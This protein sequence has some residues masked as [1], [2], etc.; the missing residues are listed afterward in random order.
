M[1]FRTALIFTLILIPCSFAQEHGLIN[2]ADSPPGNKRSRD[3]LFTRR[4]M[5][6]ERKRPAAWNDLVYGGQF[7]DRIEAMPVQG[8]RTFET[9]GGDNVKPRYTDNGIE[10]DEWSYWGGNSIPGQDGRHHLIVCRWSEHLPKGHWHYHES[11]V[12]HAVSENPYGPY[13]VE[14]TLFRGHN[15]YIFQLQDGR[16]AIEGRGKFWVSTMKEDST[17]QFKSMTGLAEYWK[18]VPI[19]LNNRARA[20]REQSPMGYARREDGS[21]LMVTRHGDIWISETGV[22]PYYRIT[23]D[24]VYPAIEGRFEDPAIW[25][26]DVQYHL[27]M[28]DWQ[29]R[30]AYH[31]R[32]K[33]GIHWKLDPGVAY[34]PERIGKVE[35]GT[36][37]DWHKY[38]VVR[39]F[40]D[41]HGRATRANFA[42]IDS[43]KAEDLGSDNHN[44]KNLFIPLTPGKQLSMQNE[45]SINVATKKI[46]VKI[47]AEEG[48]NPHTDM[49]LA[50]LRFGA[51]EEVDFGRGCELLNTKKA[52]TD[53][54]LIFNGAGN[55]FTAGNF[56]GKLLGKTMEG[57]LLFGY[58]RL[59]GVVYQEPAL[60]AL[61]AVFTPIN[62]GMKIEVEVQN[63]GQVVSEPSALKVIIGESTRGTGNACVINGSIPPLQ[64][65]EK[66]AVEMKCTEDTTKFSKGSLYEVTVSIESPGQK[67]ERLVRQSVQLIE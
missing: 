36:V 34:E 12:V 17:V 61:P 44:S 2:N 8:E 53:L 10:D 50:S 46:E 18:T 47:L 14:E 16:Y 54:I 39:I 58:S 4:P 65:F 38:E 30:I 59:P 41:E 62:D 64:P 35:D 23:D 3:D 55:G 25:R 7:I 29:G 9:W 43:G 49:D 19:I 26:T 56:A 60:S 1:T 57:Q 40:Q 11:L 52:G 5:S 37:N 32:S 42:A 63:F 45:Q 20:K 22:S 21:F 27:I 67:P 28:N 6:V 51:P 66:T 48:F 15:P 13:K 33:D 31:M 24:R